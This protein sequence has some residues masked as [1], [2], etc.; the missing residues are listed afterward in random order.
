[1]ILVIDTSSVRSAMGLV[2]PGRV[3][4]DELQFDSRE[5]PIAMQFPHIAN[6]VRLAKIAVATG[7]GSFTGVRSGV[8]FGLGLAIGLR[9]PIV[10][11]PTL[12]IQA[13]RTEE[14]VLAVSEAGRGRVYYLPPGGKPAVG[15]PRELPRDHEVVGWVRPQTERSMVAAGLRFRPETRL[16]RWIEGARKVLET[17][18]EVPYRN[19]E[20]EYMQ[21]F[22]APRK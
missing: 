9:I 1:M 3:R 15:E 14:P 12:A 11:L 10:P 2:D 17:A 18:P 19:L 4:V 16:A 13:A 21:S 8:S 5:T 22:S 6:G 7:P 20:I